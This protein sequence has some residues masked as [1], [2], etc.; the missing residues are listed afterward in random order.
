MD[1]SGVLHYLNSH[2]RNRSSDESEEYGSQEGSLFAVV[3]EKE[4]QLDVLEVADLV[5]RDHTWRCGKLIYMPLTEER[6]L[7]IDLGPR[8]ALSPT[9]LLLWINPPP[10]GWIHLK[11]TAFSEVTAKTKVILQCHM[12][13][14][15]EHVL[16]ETTDFILCHAPITPS[17]RELYRMFQ[18]E[19][20][21][22]GEFPSKLMEIELFGDYLSSLEEEVLLCQPPRFQFE[23]EYASFTQGIFVPDV[24]QRADDS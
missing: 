12:L 15:G 23:E 2:S 16:R 4:R 6:K 24:F 14:F 22:D 18:L 21:F 10:R 9:G 8:K 3:R 19:V 20:A 7:I 13:E 17:L 1:T 5:E 11:L